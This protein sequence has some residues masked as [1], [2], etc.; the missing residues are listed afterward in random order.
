MSR[1]NHF[2]IS[3]VL[4]SQIVGRANFGHGQ[5]ASLGDAQR[6]FDLLTTNEPFQLSGEE[7]RADLDL[8]VKA[9]HTIRN[10]RG[11]RGSADLYI[12]DPERN[13]QFIDQCRSLGLKSSDYIIN[14][15]IMYAR[16]NNHLGGLNSV[17]TSI[18]YD[19]FAF[20]SEFAATELKYKYGATIDDIICDPRLA[21]KFDGVARRLSPGH[22]PFEYRWAIL[23][24][25]KAGRHEKLPADFQIPKFAARFH[26]ITDP[27]DKVPEAS[28]VYLLYE[29]TQLLYVR[30]TKLLR[31][32]IELHRQASA[33]D[34]LTNKFWSPDPRDFV[35]RYSVMR[36]EKFLRPLEK[37][38]VEERKPVF[39]VPRSAA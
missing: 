23:S 4:N 27:L 32:G 6:Y 16:K 12:A 7:E 38:L 18:D 11:D 2:A 30:S 3:S 31:H 24:I 26:L 19:D 29:K 25:R 39:N 37:R 34:A 5:I 1:V 28:G 35:V 13:T 8:V 15:T 10:A 33:L 17:K 14:K 22:S 21:S 9:F 20:A 36:E